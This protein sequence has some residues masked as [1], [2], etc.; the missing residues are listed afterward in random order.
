MPNNSDSYRPTIAQV[1]SVLR[2]R[3]KDKYGSELGTFNNDTRPTAEQVED[4][5]DLAI[6]D[7]SAAIGQAVPSVLWQGVTMLV[8]INTANLIQAS[9]WPEQVEDN[10]AV[11]D[12][13]T[14]WYQNGLKNMAMAVRAENLGDDEGADGTADLPLWGDGDA[15]CVAEGAEVPFSAIWDSY[16]RSPAAL[17][18]SYDQLPRWVRRDMGI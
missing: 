13:W 11:F 18:L 4:L 6:G 16:M 3:T 8:A 12:F 14:T 2:A 17:S 7:T 15:I 10:S 1:G 9:Y 5:I